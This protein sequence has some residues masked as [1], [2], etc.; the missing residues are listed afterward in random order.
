MGVWIFYTLFV[1][2]AYLLERT[3]REKLES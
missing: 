1:V 3:R 2:V